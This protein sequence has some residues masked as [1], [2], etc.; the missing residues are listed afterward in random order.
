MAIPVT[1]NLLLINLYFASDELDALGLDPLWQ[2]MNSSTGGWPMVDPN[3][4]PASF[5]I[6]SSLAYL[7][8]IKLD[9]AVKIEID[10]DVRNTTR[11]LIYVSK[12][13]IIFIKPN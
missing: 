3:W 2:L 8:D 13:K 6:E 10:I 9:I 1:Q 7:R 5:D 4:D 12:S 11:N